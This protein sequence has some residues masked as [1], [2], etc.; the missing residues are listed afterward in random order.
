[1]VALSVLHIIY[2]YLFHLRHTMGGLDA[3]VK[4]RDKRWLEGIHFSGE[5]RPGFIQYRVQVK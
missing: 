4:D 3:S 1:M 2:V 5:M